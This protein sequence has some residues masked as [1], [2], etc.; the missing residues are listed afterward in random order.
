MGPGLAVLGICFWSTVSGRFGTLADRL[1]DYRAHPDPVFE[2][3]TT[4]GVGSHRAAGTAVRVANRERN[5]TVPAPW[6]GQYTE[7]VLTGVRG[8]D[9]DAVVRLMDAGVVTGPPR[10]P[11]RA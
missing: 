2:Q 1:F 6:R 4:P 9:A 8:L 7:E 10:D 3:R 5:A 11:Y